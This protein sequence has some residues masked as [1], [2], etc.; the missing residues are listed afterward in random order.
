MNE[1]T[2]QT[3][4]NF[5]DVAEDNYRYQVVDSADYPDGFFWWLR[6]NPHIYAAFRKRA[7]QMANLGRPR[8]SARTI[9]E[10]IRWNTEL[11]QSDVTFKIGN[12]YTPGMARLWMKEFGQRFPGFFELRE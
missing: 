8:Y 10:V 1:Q 6:K 12:N 3:S 4:M 9:V 7:L 2:P 11:K 5:G